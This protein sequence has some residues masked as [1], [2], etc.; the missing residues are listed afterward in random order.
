[1]GDLFVSNQFVF[2]EL[3]EDLIRESVEETCQKDFDKETLKTFKN[4]VLK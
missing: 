4:L 3:I 2:V 1:V